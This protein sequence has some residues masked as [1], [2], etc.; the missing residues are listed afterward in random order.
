MKKIFCII[1]CLGCFF[2]CTKLDESSA[3]KDSNAEQSV[4]ASFYFQTLQVDEQTGN[5]TYYHISL[6]PIIKLQF[7]SA[8]DTTTV[9]ANI[10][11]KE[12]AS[13]IPV[14]YSYQSANKVVVMQPTSTLKYLTKYTVNINSN[15]QSATHVS[16]GVSY[17]FREITTIDSTDKFP[18]ISNTK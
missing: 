18:R 5:V 17:I 7:S 1:T 10:Q 14:S 2:S 8:V 13:L 9:A 3:L 11:L 16:L 4:A 12:N 6:H 15:L